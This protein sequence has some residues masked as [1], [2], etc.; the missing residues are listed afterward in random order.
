MIHL[1]TQMKKQ[2]SNVVNAFTIGRVWIDFRAKYVVR[3]E[4]SISI[5][6]N[7]ENNLVVI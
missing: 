2:N 4:T 7:G 6:V 5:P 3:S 1:N